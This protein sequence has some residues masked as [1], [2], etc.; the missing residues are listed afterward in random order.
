MN[1]NFAVEFFFYF[2]FDIVD[3]FVK[4]EDILVAG[5]FRMEGYENSRGAVV[6]N[7]HVVYSYD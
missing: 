3:A 6:V 5:Y 1:G 4:I 2:V 7:Y